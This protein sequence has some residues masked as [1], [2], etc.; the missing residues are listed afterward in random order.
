MIVLRVALVSLIATSSIALTGCSSL[1]RMISAP[2]DPA[3]YAALVA[4]PDRTPEDRALDAGRKPAELLVFTGV[5]PGMRVAELAAGGGYT[6]ELLA[7]AVAPTGQVYGQNTPALLQRFLEKPWSTRLERPVMKGVIRL[8]RTLD[9]PFPA[10]VKDLDAVLFVLF[11]HDT[12][13]LN[14]DRGRMNRA[15]FAALKP[16]GSYV[17]VDHSGRAGTGTSEGSTLHRIEESVVRGEIEAAGFK[18]A[19]EG[20]FLREPS[21]P[22][23]WNASPRQAAERRGQSDRFVLRF[24]K[25]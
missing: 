5:T 18:L 15:I 21:D 6:A 7:R 4:A 24:V 19:S 10:D 22:R 2:P 25:P 1:S 14:V 3:R 23:D 17:V 11:Y 8:D 9:D 12:V 20:S 16:G 13:A